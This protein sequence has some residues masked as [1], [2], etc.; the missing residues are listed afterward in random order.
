MQVM[1]GMVVSRNPSNYLN[2]WN[3]WALIHRACKEL[4]LQRKP[5]YY[6]NKWNM[7]VLIHT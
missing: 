3:M 7:H 4:L 2:K 1:Q 6:L 5:S